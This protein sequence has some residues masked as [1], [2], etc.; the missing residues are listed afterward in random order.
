MSILNYVF[1]FHLEQNDIHII[2]FADMVRNFKCE[3][4]F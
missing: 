4:L 2:Y 1:N 3:C